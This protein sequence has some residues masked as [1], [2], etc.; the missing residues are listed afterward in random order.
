MKDIVVSTDQQKDSLQNLK[1]A[2]LIGSYSWWNFNKIPKELTE[3]SKIFITENDNISGYF[4]IETIDNQ[5]NQ[6]Y[7]DRWQD[8]E[9]V[10]SNKINEDQYRVFEYVKK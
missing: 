8:I 7:F 9:D 1:D 6:V 2:L 4:S 10:V 3:K 5:T